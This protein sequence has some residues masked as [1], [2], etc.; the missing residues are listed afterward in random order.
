[1][2]QGSSRLHRAF[3]ATVLFAALAVGGAAMGVST[4]AAAG[5]EPEPCTTKKFNFKDV[6]KA[7]KAGGRKAAKKFMKDIVK[8]AKAAGEKIKCTS[9]HNDTK[10]YANTPTAVADFRKWLTAK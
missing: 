9:C 5:D 6:E 3:P 2:T 1:M 8:K 7:C 4:T 10:S